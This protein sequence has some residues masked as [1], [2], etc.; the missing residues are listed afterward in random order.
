LTTITALIES[1]KN[2]V[3]RKRVDLQ[4]LA[5]EMTIIMKEIGASYANI[6]SDGIVT[7][8]YDLN[9]I[10]KVSNRDNA[11]ICNCTS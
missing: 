5:E 2:Q 7:I 3:M 6:D 1:E 10:V 8:V 9:P 4:I 11:K